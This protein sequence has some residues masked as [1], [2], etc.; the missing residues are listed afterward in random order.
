MKRILLIG[1]ALL[2]GGCA[3][4]RPASRATR[5][6]VRKPEPPARAVEHFRAGALYDFTDQY[7]NALLE[8]YQAL[9]YDSTSA[10]IYKAI[11]RDLM[12]LENYESALQYLQ[13]GLRLAPDD[14]EIL[15]YLAEIHYQLRH[16]AQSARYFERFL[17]LDPYNAS[18]QNNLLFLYSQMDSVD[19]VIALRKKL[20]EV[21]GLSDENT[22]QLISL[23]LKTKRFS[24]AE[25]L[26]NRLVAQNPDEPLNWLLK[27]NLLMEVHRDTTAAIQAYQKA[28]ELDTNNQEIMARLYRL[29]QSRGDWKG[30]V[31]TFEHLLNR[32][33][34]DVQSRLIM[35]E[36]LFNLKQYDR[37]RQ[38]V[39]PLLDSDDYADQA[40]LLLGRIADA[41]ENHLQAA[42]YFRK[43]TRLQP[44][45]KLA[46]L[47]L[48]L[49]YS[50]A[51]H[52]QEAL[53]S[54][55]EALDLFPEDLDLLSFYG[56]TLNQL[57]RYEEA[58][59]ILWKV[60]R[61][62]PQDLNTVVALG[63]ALENLKQFSRLDSLYD[64]A[65]TLHPD[66]AILLNNYSYSLAE[67]GIRLEEALR[68]A[69]KAVSL[70]P[71]NGAY[72]DTIGWIYYKL[73]NLEQA[74]SY[75]SKAVQLRQDSPVVI[76]HLGDV[77]FKM[78]RREEALKYW[79]RA[80]ELDPQNQALKEKISLP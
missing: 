15:Y 70:E 45:N 2:V 7:K 26:L 67:R 14:R 65:L 1:L 71:D 41:Q 43:V 51:G 6:L 46:W 30:L 66:A 58:A 55:Q 27:G 24:E 4:S 52:H 57:A 48:A 23:Y 60:N 25:G 47:S 22:Y 61:K 54:L 74:A 28:L 64:A 75:L 79:R 49:S 21:R 50:Q 17:N 19:K 32:N 35:A 68:M 42:E 13:R 3:A 31:T 18:V 44:K 8:Y 33:P 62:A 69:Q 80:L 40:Y 78:G 34:D 11:G 53:K 76:E 5:D 56:S 59:K 38:V 9:V 12:R 16:F 37:A 39:Q 63:V 10:E 77:Y 73:G 72:L 20:L 36:G 29:F